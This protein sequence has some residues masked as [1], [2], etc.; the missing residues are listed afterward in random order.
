MFAEANGL[1]KRETEVLGYLLAGRTTQYIAEKLFIAESTARTHVHKIYTKTEAHD[2][3]NLLDSFELFC[4]E[5]V[6]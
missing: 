3:M 2:R 5:K 6:R 4:E 1:S